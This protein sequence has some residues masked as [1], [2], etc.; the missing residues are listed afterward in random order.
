MNLW[1]FEVILNGGEAAVRDCSRLGALILWM[2]M[3]QM[4]AT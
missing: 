2:G 4:Y 3:P 1:R